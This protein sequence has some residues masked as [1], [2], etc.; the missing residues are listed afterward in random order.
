MKPPNT[1][2]PLLLPDGEPVR[3]RFLARADAPVFWEECETEATERAD[4]GEAVRIRQWIEDH[5]AAIIRVQPGPLYLCD[6]HLAT[7]REVL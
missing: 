1:R 6:T 4:H 2:P 3:C 5:P 7:W